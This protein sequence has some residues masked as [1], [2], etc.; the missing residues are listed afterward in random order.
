MHGPR[1][2]GPEFVFY[3][4]TNIVTTHSQLP[5][6]LLTQPIF[7]GMVRLWAGTTNMTPRQESLVLWDAVQERLP[8][9]LVPNTEPYF[10]SRKLPYWLLLDRLQVFTY[11]RENTIFSLPELLSYQSIVRYLAHPTEYN[12][13]HIQGAGRF[14]H[15]AN[16]ALYVRES[17]HNATANMLTRLAMASGDGVWMISHHAQMYA[18]LEPWLPSMP[19]MLRY[20]Y[21]TTTA[22]VGVPLDNTPESE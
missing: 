16:T 21:P 2:T 10:H 3:C 9:N 22:W 18:L 19:T 14:A 11:D 20:L 15:I 6:E 1:N 13:R 7:E 17:D 8:T 5:V 12:M 4:R